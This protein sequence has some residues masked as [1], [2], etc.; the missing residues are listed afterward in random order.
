MPGRRV[1]MSAKQ[2]PDYLTR[3]SWRWKEVRKQPSL[4]PLNSKEWNSVRSA[5]SRLAKFGER[6]IDDLWLSGDIRRFPDDSFDPGQIK[7]LSALA[8]QRSQGHGK[9]GGNPG[10]LGLVFWTSALLPYF[11]FL[12]KKFTWPELAELVKENTGDEF[13]G[14]DLQDRWIKAKAG[15]ALR[16]QKNRKGKEAI[17]TLPDSAPFD[18]AFLFLRVNKDLPVGEK[19]RYAAIVLKEIPFLRHTDAWPSSRTLGKP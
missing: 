5:S 15:M 13:T 12:G 3:V 17:V 18:A 2:Q 19:R 1:G 8:F 9:P 16:I 4:K 10:S 6:L 14:Q 7:A 11:R